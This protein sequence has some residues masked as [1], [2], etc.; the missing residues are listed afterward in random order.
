MCETLWLPLL[1]KG[2]NRKACEGHADFRGG[3]KTKKLNWGF[4]N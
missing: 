3:V 1:P 4:N 2:G